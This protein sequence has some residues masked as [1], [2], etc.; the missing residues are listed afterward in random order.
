MKLNTFVDALHE[1]GWHAI[2]D[3]QHS[4]IRKLHAK[5]FPII[6]ELEEDLGSAS[7]RIRELE[8]EAGK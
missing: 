4:E 5:L 8:K 6:A 3:A 2:C 7:A 1:A